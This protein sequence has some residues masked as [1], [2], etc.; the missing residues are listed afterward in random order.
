M[1]VVL[2]HAMFVIDGEPETLVVI[3][4][5]FDADIAHEIGNGM[6][7]E[8]KKSVLAAAAGAVF[9]MGAARGKRVD[10]VDPGRRRLGVPPS[11]H[12]VQGVF[13]IQGAVQSHRAYGKLG[14]VVVRDRARDATLPPRRVSIFY[15]RPG[16]RRGVEKASSDPPQFRGPG[17][18][19]RFGGGNRRSDL[20][21]QKAERRN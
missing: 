7:T 8:I 9:L 17:G 21:S 11:L 3:P 19:V 18:V 12:P 10:V 2:V 4:H 13:Q 16:P 15:K 20:R 1:R 5:R 14:S 6:K